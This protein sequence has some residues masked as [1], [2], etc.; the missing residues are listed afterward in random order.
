MLQCRIFRH[1][2]LDIL[3]ELALTYEILGIR[4]LLVDEL[5]NYMILRNRSLMTPYGLVRLCYALAT[6]RTEAITP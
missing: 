3:H 2:V 5:N 6:G 1:M 4:P